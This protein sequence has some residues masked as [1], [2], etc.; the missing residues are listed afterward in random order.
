MID[1][2]RTA[3][4]TGHR[5]IP[6]NTKKQ[7]DSLLDRVIEDL[8]KK[9]VVFYGSGGAYGFDMLA[10][11]AVLRAK[12][13]HSEI[14]LILVL[15]CKDH[16]KYWTEEN[17]MQFAEILHKADKVVY[18]A[19]SYFSGCMHKRNRHLVSYSGYCVAYSV[20]NSGGTAYTI[21]YAARN[22]LK[23]VNLVEFLQR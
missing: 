4:F 5:E 22:G 20:K 1:R 2:L 7:L 6:E 9:G 16:D 11:L 15:P 17:K 23:I 8:Y 14:K 19:D 18:T 13:R 3:C 12:Q 10:E 21:D